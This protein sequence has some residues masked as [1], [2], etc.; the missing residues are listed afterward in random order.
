MS[1]SGLPGKRVEA[2][3][4]GMTIRTSLSD[5]GFARRRRAE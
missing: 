3:R 1:A 2:M 4:A 5:I